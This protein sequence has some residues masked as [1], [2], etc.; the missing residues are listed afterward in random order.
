[1]ERNVLGRCF[2][3]ANVYEAQENHTP[4][5]PA[6]QRIHGTLGVEIPKYNPITFS[7]IAARIWNSQRGR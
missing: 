2:Q 4:K 1:M 7:N 6:V 3:N 5:A